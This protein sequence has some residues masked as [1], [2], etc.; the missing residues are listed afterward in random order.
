MGYTVDLR[1]EPKEEPCLN[2]F[3]NIRRTLQIFL[4]D[5]CSFLNNK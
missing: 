5:C 3:C 4:I 1:K 2:A